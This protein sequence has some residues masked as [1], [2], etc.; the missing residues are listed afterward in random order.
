MKPIPRKHVPIGKCGNIVQEGDIFRKGR[1]RRINV[2]KETVQKFLRFPSTLIENQS[3]RK[4]HAIPIGE[5]RQR[6]GEDDRAGEAGGEMAEIFA[7]IANYIII[8]RIVKN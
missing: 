8:T 6:S 4:L 7:A 3:I 1:L 5:P 2:L